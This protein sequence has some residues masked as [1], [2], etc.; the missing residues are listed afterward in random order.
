M[1]LEDDLNSRIFK[2]SCG[3]FDIRIDRQGKWYY[4]GSL[5]GRTRMV[6]LF[7]TALNRRKDGSYWLTTPIEDG[8][9]EV[10]DVPF[11][12]IQ[13]WSKGQ[14]Y[15]RSIHFYTNVGD[16]VTLDK[17]HP[18]RII[19][20]PVTEEPSPYVLVRG[21]MEARLSRS[22][23][24]NLVDLGQEEDTPQGHLYG[25][26]SCGSFFPLGSVAETS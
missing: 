10:E 26:W 2:A 19:H 1:T 15:N 7:A 25:V 21:G 12:V 18:L 14:D 9:I 24:Y 20:N 22:V 23:Y 6:G 16:E 3:D 8:R 4:R 17:S 11:V 13:M 5:I